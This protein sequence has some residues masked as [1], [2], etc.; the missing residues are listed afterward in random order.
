MVKI[1]Q[2]FILLE[3]C[4]KSQLQDLFFF[5][6]K[7]L[8]ISFFFFFPLQKTNKIVF[9]EEGRSELSC[10]KSSSSIRARVV[11]VFPLSSPTSTGK[12]CCQQGHGPRHKA[13]LTSLVLGSWESG[14]LLGLATL[15]TSDSLGSCPFFLSLADSVLIWL[16]SGWLLKLSLSMIDLTGV[17]GDILWVW[18]WE[19]GWC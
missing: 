16:R 8:Y 1:C 9:L 6:Q 3:I 7:K 4:Q 2:V 12:V 10:F 17:D 18:Q 19:L 5:P 11:V 14:A 13:I 15:I